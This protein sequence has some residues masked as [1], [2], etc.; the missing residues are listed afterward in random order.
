MSNTALQSPS[1]TETQERILDAAETLFAERGFAATS[2]RAIAARAEVNLAATHYHFGSKK[3]L[4]AAVFHRR[5]APINALRLEGLQQ[6]ED[7]GEAL[8]VGNILEAFFLPFTRDDMYATAPAVIGWIYGE[9]EVITKPI[10]EREFT[11][12]ARRYQ[13]TLAKVLPRVT[14]DDLR[15]RFHFMVGSMIHLL[16]M[17]APLGVTSSRKSFLRGLERLITFSIAGLEQPSKGMHDG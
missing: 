2:L 7:S 1:S 16:Q 10:F 14:R 11:T 6:L 9:P 13:R 12:V 3:G 17:N 15:W 5:I 4:L 8:T